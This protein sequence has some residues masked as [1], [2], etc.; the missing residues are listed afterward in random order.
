[1]FNHP[2]KVCMTYFKHCKFSLYLSYNFAKAS[3]KAFVHALIPDLYITD[4]S[5]TIKKLNQDMQNVGC[6][7]DKSN[8]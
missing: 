4:S 5:D 2:N 6:K 3:Y 7:D 8:N 1:M